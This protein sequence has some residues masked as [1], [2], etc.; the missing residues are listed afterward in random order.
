MSNNKNPVKA[1]ADACQDISNETG[2]TVKIIDPHGETI[3]ASPANDRTA[4]EPTQYH[5]NGSNI[6][7]IDIVNALKVINEMIDS[8]FMQ[9]S[10]L[11][12]NL[13]RTEAYSYY[14]Y[15]SSKSFLESEINI[16]GSIA[17]KLL[18]IYK[19]FHKG[20]GKSLWELEVIGYEKLSLI[21]NIVSALDHW[22]DK[23][24]WYENAQ[25]MSLSSLKEAVFEYKENEKAKTIDYKK[26]YTDQIFNELVDIFATTKQGLPLRLA[27]F[28]D[29]RYLQLSKTTPEALQLLRRDIQKYAADFKQKISQYED[30]KNQDDQSDIEEIIN[31]STRE[32]E[33]NK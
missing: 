8:K 15:E 27:L 29:N 17:S 31:A 23:E 24:P 6:Q 18:K 16:S 10:E 30:K 21:V 28:F 22:A 5:G 26:I 20:M 14:G 25:N 12:N 7:R 9:L 32:E 2:A 3:I 4:N 33:V 11:L 13:K 1:F 19:T